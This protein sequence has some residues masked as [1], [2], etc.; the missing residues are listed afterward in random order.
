M[1]VGDYVLVQQN[2]KLVPEKVIDVSKIE[3]Q[4]NYFVLYFLDLNK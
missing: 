3:I 4:G 2:D 1:T